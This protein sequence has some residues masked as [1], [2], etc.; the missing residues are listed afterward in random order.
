MDYGDVLSTYA[1][2]TL[3]DF[4]S[5]WITAVFTLHDYPGV[6]SVA[7]SFHI[8]TME[9]IGKTGGFTLHDF[10]NKKNRPTTLS[11]TQTTAKRTRE[12]K[13]K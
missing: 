6:H 12:V 13:R 8:S 7:A 5:H 1:K 2:F 4:E 3:H 11:G 10:T 9:W